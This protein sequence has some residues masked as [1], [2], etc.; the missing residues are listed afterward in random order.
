MQKRLGRWLIQ[1]FPRGLHSVGILY[2][3][4]YECGPHV[5]RRIDPSCALVSLLWMISD[6]CHVIILAPPW[7]L[8][9]FFGVGPSSRRKIVRC[10]SWHYLVVG[11]GVYQWR[12]MSLSSNLCECMAS[13]RDHC[14]DPRRRYLVKGHRE[15]LRRMA[16]QVGEAGLL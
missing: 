10:N 2:I 5:S 15:K 12:M 13:S 3:K 4:L 9:I 8:G 7:P 16:K 6:S 11:R 14:F 1:M